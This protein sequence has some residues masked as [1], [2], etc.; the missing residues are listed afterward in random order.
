[1]ILVPSSISSV[2]V[3]F[4]ISTYVLN[5]QNVTTSSYFIGHMIYLLLWPCLTDYL[6]DPAVQAALHVSTTPTPQPFVSTLSTDTSSTSS[7]SAKDNSPSEVVP[8]TRRWDFCSDEVNE[9]WAENDLFAD[10]TELYKLIYTHKHKPKDFK[11]LVF[12]G[13][14]DGVSWF[15]IFLLY[16]LLNW[17]YPALHFAISIHQLY[18]KFE[19]N[20]CL[21]IHFFLARSVPQ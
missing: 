6:N 13:D 8:N 11:M 18:M 9:H 17:R 16:C 1:M 19:L 12:S 7:G 5:C 21:F 4:E 15:G 20:A 3:Y 14:I 10:T 2:R